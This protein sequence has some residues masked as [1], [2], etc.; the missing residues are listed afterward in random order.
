MDIFMYKAVKTDDFFG[1][2]NLENFLSPFC[3]Q[4]DADVATVYIFFICLFVCLNNFFSLW[5]PSR[6][7]EPEKLYDDNIISK[8]LIYVKARDCGHISSRVP[9]GDNWIIRYR[10]LYEIVGIFPHVFRTVTTEL[11]DIGTYKSDCTLQPSYLP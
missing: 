1:S 8:T 3:P 6:R 10:Y 9:H 4:N 7:A 11:S 5:K 2:C